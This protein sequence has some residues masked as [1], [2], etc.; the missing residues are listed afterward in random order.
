MSRVEYSWQVALQQSLLPLPRPTQ[1]T[2]VYMFDLSA[3]HW[4]VPACSVTV[5]GSFG[6][7]YTLPSV[8]R[9]AGYLN[10]SSWTASARRC[11]RKWM[12][13]HAAI[14]LVLPSDRGQL[15]TLTIYAPGEPIPTGQGESPFPLTFT[16]HECPPQVRQLRFGSPGARNQLGLFRLS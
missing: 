7:Q 1:R 10:S 3:I 12:S 14:A 8:S 9:S 16:Y 2:R 15:R 5:H 6:S 11:S 13:G 4:P